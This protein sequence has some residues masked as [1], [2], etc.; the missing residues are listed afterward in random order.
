MTLLSR[1]STG[2]ALVLSVTA[3][4]VSRPHAQAPAQTPDPNAAYV[5]E[6]VSVKPNKSGQ[7]GSSI[8]RQPGGRLTASNM[9]LRAL[10]TF[11]YQIQGFQLVGDPSWLR[12]ETFDIVAK[13]EGDPPPV[14][15]GTGPDPHM[16]AMRTV[17]AERFKLAVHRETRELDIYALVL[18]RPD[19]T[20]GPNLKQT[21]T[22]CLAMMDAARRGGAPPPP[23][24]P[25]APVVCGMRGTFGKLL[26]NAMPMSQFANNLSS[27]MQRVVVDR[28]GLTGGWDF[29][30]TFAPEPP[31]GP[32]P[33]GVELPPPDPGAPSLVTAIQEQLG[34]RLQSTK[35]PV[36]VLVVDRIEQLIPD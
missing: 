16:V 12:T 13:M 29:E 26:V 23:P 3:L 31:A 19:G 6:A 9:P 2:T 14:M 7:Q 33:P 32:L 34:L 10:I 27:Q 24:G 1:L 36:E 15:P 25:N 30:L 18:A 8:R 28:T 5:Y 20:L 21:T 17:L 35:G 4:S 22:D 11:A